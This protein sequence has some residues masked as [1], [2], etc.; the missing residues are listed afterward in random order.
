MT[1][2]AKQEAASATHFPTEEEL[3]ASI[4]EAVDCAASFDENA[5]KATKDKKHLAAAHKKI[6]ELVK[7]ASGW[8]AKYEAA[9]DPTKKAAHAVRVLQAVAKSKEEAN[10]RRKK[11]EEWGVEGFAETPL[12]QTNAVDGA[13][14]RP[15]PAPRVQARRVVPTT[16]SP[17]AE[18]PPGRGQ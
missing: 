6:D 2:P 8:L 17:A 18:R 5:V 14:I 10:E 7:R 12:T 13:A 16:H 15:R 11:M 1:H 9:S 3:T 4:E